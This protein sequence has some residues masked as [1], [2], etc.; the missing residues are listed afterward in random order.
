MKLL[1]DM[2]MSPRWV[3]VLG[4]VGHEGPPPAVGDPA[5]ADA[6]IMAVAL[7]RGAVVRTNDLDFGTIL[8]A[9]GAP[10]PSVVQLRSGDL[11]PEAVSKVV[12]AAL[13]QMADE[14]GKVPS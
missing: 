4:N 1:V 8:A 2:N 13:A 10:G 11:R 5:A 6:T 3:V 14:L 9:S 12:L 7:E